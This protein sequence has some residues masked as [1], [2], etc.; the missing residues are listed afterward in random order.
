MRAMTPWPGLPIGV[1]EVW[2]EPRSRAVL[3]GLAAVGLVPFAGLGAVAAGWVQPAGYVS[4]AVLPA[5]ALLA[6]GLLWVWRRERHLL[7]RAA[8]GML[9]GWLGTLAYDALI[10]T[11]Q[12]FGPGRGPSLV[13]PGVQLAPGVQA[14]D[15]VAPAFALHW[16]GLGALWGMTYALFAGRAHWAWG[17]VFGVALWTTGLAMAAFLPNGAI[18]VPALDAGR[19]ALLLAGHLLFGAMLGGVNQLLQP[20]PPFN[21]KI[22]FLRDYVAQKQIVRR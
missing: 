4:G 13:W 2:H 7:D 11:L 5:I 15:L 16:L 10:V 12:T 8:V 20:A 18:V 1:G 22:V 19:A 17:L 9:A 21:A 3:L 14:F 6:L